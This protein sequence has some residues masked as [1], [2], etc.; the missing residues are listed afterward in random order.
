[1]ANVVSTALYGQ[2]TGSAKAEKASAAAS[3]KGR[4]K[5][6]MTGVA[7]LIIAAVIGCVVYALAQT[8]N[9]KAMTSKIKRG[10]SEI[11]GG[12]IGKKPNHKA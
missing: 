1:M 12:M 7:G 10:V 4:N 3:S 5:G 11:T 2:S 6:V 8:G 9:G